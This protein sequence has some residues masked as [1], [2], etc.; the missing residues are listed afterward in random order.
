[1]SEMFGGEEELWD[2]EEDVFAEIEAAVE[3]SREVYAE[4]DEAPPVV[5]ADR[6]LPAAYA[7]FEPLEVRP[8]DS[9]TMANPEWLWD[10]RIPLNSVSVIEGHP[11]IGKSSV[12][13]DLVARMTTGRPWPGE[14]G[15]QKNPIRKVL[16]LTLEDAPSF[17]LLPRLVAAGGDPKNVLVGTT[18]P[19]L[20]GVRIDAGTLEVNRRRF[21][22]TVIESGADVLV[23]DP[24]S[25]ALEDGNSEPIARQVFSG[26]YQLGE[27][28]GVTTLWIR[29]LAKA[30]GDRSPLMAGIGSIG[31]AAAARSVLQ[32]IG[33]EKQMEEGE[34]HCRYLCHVKS[35][36]SKHQPTLSYGI[37][38]KTVPGTEENP[39]Y[40]TVVNWGGEV[41]VSARGLNQKNSTG[42]SARSR[43]DAVADGLERWFQ[44]K[45]RATTGEVVDKINELAGTNATELR[46]LGAYWKPFVERCRITEEGQGRARVFV[47]SEL[48]EK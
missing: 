18:L 9:Y 10:Q 45:E 25:A 21:G 38:G 34:L 36:L 31:V 15:H 47:Y 30:S 7:D 16:W 3:K 4:T 11:G 1:M 35:N 42:G 13:M 2:E 48:S 26:L 14:P 6:A 20:G 5:H 17:T 27:R 22:R 44:V 37:Q 41:G 19:M 46:K 8:L 12:I 24:G 39:I 33:D 32:M 43:K 40:S 28:Y 23:L 29:H